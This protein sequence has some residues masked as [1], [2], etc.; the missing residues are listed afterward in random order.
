MRLFYLSGECNI[1]ILDHL[2]Y[3]R[4]VW[5]CSYYGEIDEYCVYRHGSVGGAVPPEGDCLVTPV[6]ASSWGAVK[7]LYR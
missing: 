2:E 1:R 6:E 3:G 4:A 5:D 7:A